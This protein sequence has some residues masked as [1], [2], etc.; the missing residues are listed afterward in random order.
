MTAP[1]GDPTTDAL[2]IAGALV[3]SRIVP[4]YGPAGVVEPEDEIQ[5]FQLYVLSKMRYHDPARGKVSTFVYTLF[6]QWAGLRLNARL[7]RRDWSFPFDPQEPVGF[8][9]YEAERVVL[10]MTAPP[11][12]EDRHTLT[13]EAQAHL[14]RLPERIRGPVETHLAYGAS[15]TATAELHGVTDRTV[16]RY[17]KE[18]RDIW[19]AEREAA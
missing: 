11:L 15:L 2:N 19:R 10:G 3:R 13:G 9:P 12:V 1:T 8:T 17:V 5:D 18:A 16:S 6:P 4:V 14:D 7:E